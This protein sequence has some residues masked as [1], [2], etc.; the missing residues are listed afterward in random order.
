[1]HGS[2]HL[3]LSEAHITAC[4]LAQP[5][6]L[7]PAAAHRQRQGMLLFKKINRSSNADACYILSLMLQVLNSVQPHGHTSLI[8]NFTFVRGLRC[9]ASKQSYKSPKEP[10]L[11]LHRISIVRCHVPFPRDGRKRRGTPRPWMTA[12]AIWKDLQSCRL[13]WTGLWP[14]ILVVGGNKLTP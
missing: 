5:H 6:G 7:Q 2:I 1:M 14:F 4:C 8:C 12:S 11:A 9:L 3:G 13:G 10:S